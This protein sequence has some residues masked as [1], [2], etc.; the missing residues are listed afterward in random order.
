MDILK[1]EWWKMDK[2][3]IT[4]LGWQTFFF[5]RQDDKNKYL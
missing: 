3:G 2:H 4:V 5:L 1:K